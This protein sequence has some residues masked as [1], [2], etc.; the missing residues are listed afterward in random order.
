MTT[1]PRTHSVR[2][3]W[4]RYGVAAGAALAL[5]VPMASPV[6]AAADPSA[7]TASSRAATDP[8]DPTVPAAPLVCAPDGGLYA[9]SLQEPGVGRMLVT[10]ASLLSAVEAAGGSVSVADP[11]MWVTVWGAT[12]S[13]GTKCSGCV[14]DGGSGG[15]GGW[16]QTATSPETYLSTFG[17]DAMNVYLGSSGQRGDGDHSI[18][19]Y[20]GGGS[21]V[22]ASPPVVSSPAQ[23]PP[24]WDI[25]A[26]GGGGGGG[27]G[28]ST[29]YD[30]HGGGDG[31]YPAR[32]PFLAQASAQGESGG[33]G[34][35]GGQGGNTDGAGAGGSGGCGD[36]W[37]DGADGVGG[38]GGF[39]DTGQTIST[40]GLYG[41]PVVPGL[42]YGDGSNAWQQVPVQTPGMGGGGAHRADTNPL[43]CA[44]DLSESV[45]EACGGGG[46]GGFGGGGAGKYIQT[47]GAGGAGG[48]GGGSFAAASTCEATGAPSV[49]PWDSYGVGNFV[50]YVDPTQN[51]V[52]GDGA[53]P[54]PSGD[55]GTDDGTVDGTVEMLGRVVW[56]APDAVGFRTS[57][58]VAVRLARGASIDAARLNGHD[59][60]ARF[61]KG[62]HRAARAVLTVDDGVRIGENTLVVRVAR[63]ERR[64]F[65]VA[66]FVRVVDS[67]TPLVELDASGWPDAAAV[68][69]RHRTT[70][71]ITVDVSIGRTA[72]PSDH[73]RVDGEATLVRLSAG[74]GVRHGTNTVTVRAATRD[75]RTTVIRR[76]LTWPGKLP[77]PEAGPDQRAHV[78]ASVAFD[79][80][81]SVRAIGARR[82][83]VTYRWEVS[84]PTGSAAELTGTD[85]LRPQLRPDLPGVYRV[86]VT[87]TARNGA[88]AS[89]TAQVT[90][91]ALPLA[92]VSTLAE[93]TDSATGAK[94]PGV[95]LDSSWLCPETT[96]LPCGFQATTS[97]DQVQLLVLDRDTL[98][99]ESNAPYDPG[100]L[101][102]LYAALA[103]LV[104]TNGNTTVPDTGKMAILTLGSSEV[105]D[106][107]NFNKAISLI[108]LPAYASSVQSVSAPFSII[109]IPGMTTGNAWNNFG[110]TIDGGR[111]GSLDGYIKDS[112]YYPSGSTSLEAEQRVF[113]FPD[114]VQ[115]ETRSTTATSVTAEIA[116]YDATTGTFTPTDLGV[117]DTS[118][119]GLGLV[120][121][122]SLTLEP[123]STATY[124]PRS[125]DEGINWTALGTALSDAAT[126]GDGVVLVSLGRMSGFEQEP[127][128]TSFTSSVLPAIRALGGQPDL[129]ARAVNDNA[130]YSFIG[131]GGQGSE[132]SSVVAYGVPVR[133][134]EGGTTP[135]PVTDGNLTG[136]LRRGVDGR[137]LPSRAD[138]SATYTSQFNPVLYQAPV[139]WPLTPTAGATPSGAQTALA[140]LAQCTLL[141][142]T[143]N[144]VV[145]G[146]QL[147]PGQD[148]TTD[149]SGASEVTGTPTPTVVRQV[150]LSL[151]SDYVD[152]L[153]LTLNDISAL[154]YTTLFP[155]GNTVFDAAD[156]S[157]AQAQ[158]MSERADLTATGTLFDTLESEISSSSAA[159]TT[160]MTQVAQ[161]VQ[162]AYFKQQQ[163]V[164]V[165]DYGAWAQGM[166]SNFT[167][168]GATVA[169]LFAAD[170]I[171]VEQLFSTAGLFADIG[172]GFQSVVNG[173][174][175]S[176]FTDI[177]AWLLTD[178]QLRDATAAV[179]VA[180]TDAVSLQQVGLGISRDAVVADW[181]RMDTV[182]TNSQGAWAIG[183]DDLAKA[184]NVFVMATRG[185]IW[186]GYAHQL[187]TAGAYRPGSAGGANNAQAYLCQT[188]S[189]G[190]T[191][192]FIEAS[193][194]GL[195]LGLGQGV[196]YW[197][198][199]NLTRLIEGVRLTPE[200]NP[201]IMWEQG[202]QTVAPYQAVEAI[203]EQ[204]ATLG[205]SA[206]AGGAFGPW[207]WDDVFDLSRRLSTTCTGGELQTVDG[208]FYG[209]TS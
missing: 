116:R 90:V 207:F 76:R 202:T 93:A 120:T 57:W 45:N 156:F 62:R 92:Q 67:P 106:M 78:H 160:Q 19:G 105:T 101:V 41:E 10:T 104:V 110:A 162:D 173:P 75:G 44:F 49:D 64:S 205:A 100:N 193:R 146:A 131:S 166:F 136:E 26:V 29:G 185:Q 61:A 175:S 3:T 81:A 22:T 103:K 35:E 47:V 108:G 84:G 85:T 69:V 6:P 176:A 52:S 127:D 187:W 137:F 46:G 190:Q 191:S 51:C 109:G 87:A 77:L 130:T 125:S 4:R 171:G 206:D 53:P 209:Q 182:T 159:M 21:V 142:G 203:F 95:Q 144:E 128:A 115:F 119:G 189:S 7:A 112:A 155:Q 99:V 184:T 163:T 33:G 152:N 15:K 117:F 153:D 2:S 74:S 208:D 149:V 150:S 18:G 23:A 172:S 178:Q 183:S 8:T 118:G 129:L 141:P 32:A 140:W 30:G 121:F 83:S 102:G 158:L 89:D 122:N 192:P 123:L 65:A 1:R 126:A 199:Q 200:W 204:P 180:V 27:G 72:V 135:L 70:D 139:T 66:H 17:T 124:A 38:F 111:P 31:G 14:P 133:V 37:C 20:G 86:T 34:S 145:P 96:T 71:P 59:V 98:A 164:T 60:T 147:W 24:L 36:G 148:C 195:P 161:T 88:T 177:D 82:R 58:P 13:N 91:D 42:Q 113:T 194:S 73:L 201:Y 154:S 196:Q 94:V 114:V 143:D 138:P 63:G 68:V 97:D 39:G 169:S 179:D 198:L 56:P 151:R 167:T 9:C 188:S 174:D 16:A 134:G 25:V 28:G 79:A 168:V 132:S 197:P 165:T 54:T 186:K 157:Q 48:G 55:D 40:T 43:E 11:V 107:A 181:G 80:R 5:T 50:V 170:E 12:G